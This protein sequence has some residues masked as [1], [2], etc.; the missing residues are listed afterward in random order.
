MC[1]V[2]C[3][4]R[5]LEHHTSNASQRR[6]SSNSARTP[7]QSVDM[8][9]Y[10]TIILLAVGIAAVLAQVI[11][12]RISNRQSHSLITNNK[13]LSLTLPTG[14][15]RQSDGRHQCLRRRQQHHA[16]PGCR[17]QGSRRQIHHSGQRRSEMFRQMCDRQIKRF[18]VGR[19]GHQACRHAELDVRQ[20]CGRGACECGRM[21]GSFPDGGHQL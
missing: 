13:C 16:R 8:N 2:R 20:R 15:P 11:H 4:R 3:E 21:C 5:T 7:H 14:R 10:A 18:R 19:A 6:Y 1:P 12:R 17:A 9:T